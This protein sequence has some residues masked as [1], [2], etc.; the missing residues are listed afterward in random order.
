MKK[1]SIEKW[2]HVV[3]VT[4]LFAD[5]TNFVITKVWNGDLLRAILYYSGIIAWIVV[6]YSQV[7][8]LFPK[9]FINKRFAKYFF[10]LSLTL[11]S[12]FIIHT[13]LQNIDIQKQILQKQQIQLSFIKTWAVH[14]NSYFKWL[15][16]II[17]IWLVSIIYSLLKMALINKII[18]IRTLVASFLSI[19]IIVS[20][21]LGGIYYHYA[22]FAGTDKIKFIRQPEKYKSFMEFVNQ[23]E[24]AGSTLYIDIW[25]PNCGPCLHEFK[26]YADFKKRYKD[27]PVKC[28]YLAIV[29]RTP[30]I[31]KWKSII[32]KY[33]I[34]GYHMKLD[35][36]LWND[37]WKIKGINYPNIIPHYI[38]VN[39]N[40][41]IVY[42]NADRPSSGELIYKQMDMA[43][44]NNLSE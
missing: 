37:I 25:G 28:I 2:V 12:L 19:L 9:Y 38:I 11:L 3:F 6:F 31:A 13:S 15:G 20:V 17:I 35:T 29:N 41:I 43:L 44:K 1:I 5:C 23:K 26:N 22:S 4:L 36:L 16:E 7:F 24:F 18:K 32:K 40:G 21:V 33:E 30:D 42:P 39:K 10:Y 34:E 14:Y 27:K 8:W